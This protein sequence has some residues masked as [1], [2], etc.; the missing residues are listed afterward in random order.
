MDAYGSS[1]AAYHRVIGYWKHDNS[2][3]LIHCPLRSSAR[4][5]FC[6]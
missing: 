5:R 3:S 1:P 6:R 2:G 4:R